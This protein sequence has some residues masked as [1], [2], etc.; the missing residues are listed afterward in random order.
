MLSKRNYLVIGRSVEKHY[1]LEHL[2]KDDGFELTYSIQ[3]HIDE[4]LDLKVDESFFFTLRDDKRAKF[5]LFRE[6]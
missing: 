5:I 2:F 4:I 3:E 6:S 1:T